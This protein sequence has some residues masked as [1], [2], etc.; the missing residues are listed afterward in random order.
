MP[1]PYA[2][3][4]WGHAS[5][6]AHP[7]D[8]GSVSRDPALT[9]DATA[10]PPET[11]RRIFL[12]ANG[13]ERRVIS[14]QV[15]WMVHVFRHDGRTP[16]AH[17]CG[18]PSAG[19]DAVRGDLPFD[20]AALKRAWATQ[21]PHLLD[22]GRAGPA[23][24]DLI[25]WCRGHR[26]RAGATSLWHWLPLAEKAA[27]EASVC[28]TRVMRD[29]PAPVLGVAL[30]LSKLRN[31]A[32][33][34]LHLPRADLR[35][36]VAP[37][38]D[39]RG[40]H[41]N[42]ARWDGASLR[43]ARLTYA[44]LLRTDF[45]RADLRDSCFRATDASEA[46]LVATDLRGAVFVHTVAR[47]A[48]FSEARCDGLV[49]TN[50]QLDESSFH[51]ASLR[52]ASLTRGSAHGA[53]LVGVAAA[54][55]QWT[56]VAMR[57]ARWVGADLRGA[58]FGQCDLRES[59][60]RGAK[61]SDVHFDRCDLRNVRF[62]GATLKRVRLGA[63][64]QLGGTQWHGTRIRLDDAWLR[65]LAP[66]AL[67]GVVQS[68]MTLPPDQPAIRAE[69]FR[70]LLIAL[71]PKPGLLEMAPE[72]V[73][74]MHC[75]PG[76]VRHG[77]WLG[78]LLTA[79]CEA[80]GIGAHEAFAVLRGQW[81][82]QTLHDLGET[83]LSRQRAEW[84]TAPLVVELHGRCRRAG[85]EVGKA[86][87]PLAGA[88]CQTLHWTEE[89]VGQTD[90]R[91]MNA[92]RDAWFGALPP[93]VRAALSAD[94]GDPF[95]PGDS[96]LIRGDGEV[97]ARL[98]SAL[99]RC[100]LGSVDGGMPEASDMS[101]ACE[102]LP[103]WRWRGVRV[104]TRDPDSAMGYGLGTIA[105]LRSLLREFGFLSGIW[106][107]EPPFDAFFRLMG[108]WFGEAGRH[109]AVSACTEQGL[110]RSS[111]AVM[112]GMDGPEA[113]MAG[114][115]ENGRLSL[116]DRREALLRAGRSPEHARWLPAA[117]ADVDDVFRD[118]P[119][120]HSGLSGLSAH[121]AAHQAA[122]EAAPGPEAV[123][124]ARWAALAAALSWQATQPAWCVAPG[125]SGDA[126]PPDALDTCRA[127]AIAALNETMT[128]AVASR[129]LPQALALRACL[130]DPDSTSGRL[131]ERLADWLTCHEVRQLPALAQA[132]A[133]TLPWFWAIRLPLPGPRYR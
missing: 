58:E 118:A 112:A 40:S 88:I 43:G 61:L 110:S 25:A 90:V 17:A 39:F 6:A 103:G 129:H 26:A 81:L 113:S 85:D 2:V 82:A 105:H 62:A 67:E 123:R 20:K 60:L 71:G 27:A 109:R 89:G 54:R 38:A 76:H 87:W 48:D 102:T 79:S 68:W 23:V 14:L 15:A 73:P 124:R 36:L 1:I 121:Q 56:A 64:C 30:T 93:G 3:S 24:R 45:E 74:P 59:D 52:G 34:D 7:R 91:H 126:C 107:P 70:Q 133:Q 127:Y 13:D 86:V 63:G 31:A 94:G 29:W 16:C 92:L 69:V 78:A 98:P 10:A 95:G 32:L 120:C 44:N 128:D 66:S 101:L 80:G 99:I 131:A 51:R 19:A 119:L 42:G 75:L 35:G 8:A 116:A 53:R 97:A 22:D 115:D 49:S 37:G 122:H 18:R 111:E 106:P 4:R 28:A 11:L 77:D 21:F 108:R 55:S 12:R 117:Q 50:A 5:N 130:A 41:F 100:V 47:N 65:R 96:V 72:A 57:G 114:P 33:P 46:R 9:S 104:V 83:P 84:V 132:C 125:R